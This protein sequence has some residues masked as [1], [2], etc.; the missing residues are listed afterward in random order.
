MNLPNLCIRRFIGKDNLQL[1][2]EVKNGR[3][4]RKEKQKI[5]LDKK[6]L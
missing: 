3:R 1:T 6:K 2:K 4:K 5:I